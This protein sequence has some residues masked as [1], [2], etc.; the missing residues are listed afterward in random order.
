VKPEII[1]AGKMPGK[2][3][4]RFRIVDMG[5]PRPQVTASGGYEPRFHVEELRGTDRM[6]GELWLPADMTGLTPACAQDHH[7][8][9]RRCEAVAALVHGFGLVLE[10]SSRLLDP[11]HPIGCEI[12]M[13]LI[14]ERDSKGCDCATPGGDRKL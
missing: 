7:L 5:P 3:T 9:Q 6:D 13:A 10:A 14:E 8:L 12:N 4:H 1:W 2:G 11:N